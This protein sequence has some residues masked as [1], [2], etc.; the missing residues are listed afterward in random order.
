MDGSVNQ[1]APSDLAAGLSSFWARVAAPG[2]ALL[3]VSGGSDSMALM[4]LAAAVSKS[5]GAE[6]DVA[7]VDH[8]LRPGARQEAELVG[9]EARSLGLRHAIL[10]WVDEKPASGLQAA[11]RAARYRLLINHAQEIGAGAIVAAHTADDQAETVLMRLARSS[12]PRG[13]AGMVED[14]RIAAGPSGPVRLLRPFLEV[15]RKRLRD[16]LKSSGAP[17]ADDPGNEDRRFERVRARQAL[18]KFEDDEFLSVEALIRAASEMR[19]A[20]DAQEAAENARFAALGGRFGPF[21]TVETTGHLEA[22]DASL[23]ARITHAVGGDEFPPSAGAA[24]DALAQLLARGASTLAGALAERSSAGILFRREPAALFG[25][26]GV[27]PAPDHRLD[28]GARVLWD[29]RFIVDNLLGE[30]ALL[31]PIDPGVAA[32]LGGGRSAVGAPAL[33]RKGEIAA[34]AG[35]SPCFRPLIDER[36]FRRVNRFQ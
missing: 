26:A 17:F 31:R 27:P 22:E 2:R 34:V 23:F 12:G 1:E 35:E 19:A 32:S 6:F 3:A 18:A 15:R 28:P 14:V 36:F 10:D 29:R 30:P 9:K 24:R 8:G 33:F 5:G 4:R 20:A 11:A 21:G 7:T 25:R 13:L 16:F